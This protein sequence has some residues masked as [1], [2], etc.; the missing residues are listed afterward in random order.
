MH[1]SLLHSL[2]AQ[3]HQLTATDMRAWDLLLLNG[4]MNHGKLARLT[5]LSGGAVTGV[6]HK[7]ERA[8]AVIREPDPTDGRKIIV[9]AA[10]SV[11]DGPLRDFFDQFEQRVEKVLRRVFGEG[12]G[13]KS[14]P[15]GR[16]GA[17]S[18]AGG[19][20]TAPEVGARP[21]RDGAFGRR[22]TSAT[23]AEKSG[24]LGAGLRIATLWP[25]V[26]SSRDHRERSIPAIHVFDSHAARRHLVPGDRAGRA[27][28]V[29]EE[30]RNRHRADAA[31]HRRDRARDFRHLGERYVADDVRFAVRRPARG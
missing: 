13:C 28:R 18:L 24:R 14:P 27:Q 31:R 7:L 8:G 11:R 29:G 1:S 25:H 12:T 5:G 2:I 15:P 23:E 16:D 4:P 3:W 30:A 22:I 26:S 9:R 6:I 19:N 20:A 17:A 10:G 21:R